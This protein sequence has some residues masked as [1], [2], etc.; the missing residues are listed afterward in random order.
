M[1]FNPIGTGGK[2]VWTN[3]TKGRSEITT[4]CWYY[5]TSYDTNLISYWFDNFKQVNAITLE[6]NLWSTPNRIDLCGNTTYPAAPLMW[7]VLP[8]REKK[9]NVLIGL[10]TSTCANM[11]RFLRI[12]TVYGWHHAANYRQVQKSW[13]VDNDVLGKRKAGES[14]TFI[15]NFATTPCVTKCK[16]SCGSWTQLVNRID[17]FIES[18]YEWSKK[19]PTNT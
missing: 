9:L 16:A 15:V 7:A 2:S 8:R 14:V 13:W 4:W 18:Y 11:D 6:R 5:L 19:I 12:A 17:I 10:C 3:S 1:A